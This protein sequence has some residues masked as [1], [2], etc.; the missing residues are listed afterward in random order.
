VKRIVELGRLAMMAVLLSTASAAQT[1]TIESIIEQTL[2]VDQAEHQED[3][4]RAFWREAM[5]DRLSG[6]D[7]KKRSA[8]D[9]RQR[10]REL[11]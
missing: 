5:R 7:G 11:V 1:E 2:T 10:D 3:F 8:A 4:E 9:S 6:L